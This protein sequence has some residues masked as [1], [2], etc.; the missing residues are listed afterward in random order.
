MSR[1]EALAALR[2]RHHV[3]VLIIGAGINGAGLY[4]DLSLQGIDCVLCDKSDICAGASAAPSRL[5]HGGLKY[6]ETGEFGL[7]A[8]S[9][10]E[11]NL[12]L[13]NAPHYVRPLQTVI[14][15]FSWFGGIIPSI[16]RILRLPAK[17]ADRG[18][19][20]TEAG[21]T[22]YDILGRRERVMPRHRMRLRARSL[23]D[24][25]AMDKRIVATGIY[26]DAVVT[27]PERLGL[28]L[29][30]DANRAN[31]GSIAVNH[32]GLAGQDEH[33]LRLR[34]ELTGEEMSLTADVV[35]NAGGAWIDQV[36]QRLGI[37]RTYIGGTKGSHLVLDN[38]ELVRQLAGRMV[39]FGSSDGRIC[40]VYPYFGHALVGSTDIRTDDPDAAVCD[41]DEA[42]YM[43]KV[44]A[45]VFPGLEIGPEQ[46][47]YRY[48]GVR[49]LPAADASDPG[50]I[51]RDHSIKVDTLPGKSVPIFSLIGGK[52]TTFR[53][54]AEEAADRV[55]SRLNRSRRV[56]TRETVIGGGRH[57]P[58]TDAERGA[59]IA[60]VSTVSRLPEERVI[61][62][63]ARYGTTAEAVADWIAA[64]ADSSLRTLADYS[65]REIERI[66]TVELFATLGDLIF[67]RTT[68]AITGRLTREVCEEISAITAKSC[69]W[70]EERRLH[71]L[72]ST[73]RIAASRHGVPVEG[74]P[75][76][77]RQQAQNLRLLI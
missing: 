6:L 37:N 22:L 74:M 12:L 55:L 38:P 77:L 59:W 34:D 53:G 18:V 24:L 51:S 58:A 10:L 42:A 68:I 2:S 39:Y 69:G 72:E 48:C 76:D 26:Y 71:E 75:D 64:G 21:L 61:D 57:F 35:V 67:R 31:G 52:W 50:R 73:L 29:V 5:I 30:L 60:R 13:R 66:C 43:L 36:N 45:E 11:R 46:I 19:L 15:I 63:L 70:S 56:S 25:P 14:P 27:Q 3:P 54:F 41:D 65:V 20:I 1:E 28:E 33:G 9:T 7:V 32:I 16:A 4:R 62:L 44:L 8:Q 47:V 17:L 40:L 49:P 23:A